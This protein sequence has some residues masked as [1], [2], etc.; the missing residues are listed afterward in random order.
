LIRP[1]IGASEGDLTV[2]ISSQGVYERRCEKT[3]IPETEYET[4]TFPKIVIYF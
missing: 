1:I 3:L 2:I 4:M